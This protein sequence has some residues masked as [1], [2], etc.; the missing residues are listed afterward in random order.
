MKKIVKFAVLATLVVGCAKEPNV[1]IEYG[2]GSVL[3]ECVTQ[4]SVSETTK[5]TYD[6][7][8]E[9]IPSGDQFSLQLTGE[10]VDSESEQTESFS[11]YYQTIESYSETLP[12]VP[13]GDYTALI[14]YGDTSLEGATNACFV[15]ESDFE[16]I[17]RKTSEEVI[18]AT[19]SNSAIRVTTTE[20]FDN[21]YSDAEFTITT[22]A[23]NE[24]SFEPNDGQLIF[25]QPSSTLKLKGSA[26]KSQTGTSV[27]F[28][29]STIGTTEVRTLNT[30][31]VDASQAGGASITITF[32]QTLTEVK[33][34]DSELNPEV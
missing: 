30:I 28:P 33:L 9:L 4:R 31:V 3:F 20:W 8:S 6:L 2:D 17:A 27:E 19:L 15:G 7:P 1:E 23:G 32:D 16:I 14:S 25:V 24:F 29:E 12:S 13:A 26:T 11:A 10:Y 22:A 18:I 21:Y 5:A 34:E